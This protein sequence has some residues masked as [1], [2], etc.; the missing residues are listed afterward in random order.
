MR[1][2]SGW[3]RGRGGEKENMIRYWGEGDR[4]EDQMANR[5]NRNKQPQGMGGREGTPAC[6][7]LNKGLSL[8]NQD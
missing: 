6:L 7:A 8:Q 1:E 3:E 5:I 2:G 4:K